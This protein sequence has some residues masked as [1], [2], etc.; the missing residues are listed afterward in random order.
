MKYSIYPR[1]GK[2][3]KSLGTKRY[4]MKVKKSLVQ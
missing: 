3:N 4:I 2:E 1:T